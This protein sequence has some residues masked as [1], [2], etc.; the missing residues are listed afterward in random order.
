MT[1]RELQ[2]RMLY[3]VLVAGKS[4][5]F[6]ESKMQ[7][8]FGGTDEPPFVLIRRWDRNGELRNRMVSAKTGNYGKN[9]PAFAELARLSHEG[10][11][12]LSTCSPA[13]LERIRGV[14]PKTSRFFIL[15]TREDARC[16]ALDVHILRWLKQRGYEGI[17]DSTPSGS[18]YERIERMFLD[19]AERLGVTP[20]HLDAVIWDESSRYEGWDPSSLLAER[21][22]DGKDQDPGRAVRDGRQPSSVMG[23]G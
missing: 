2:L 12:D 8:L 16:A 7:T 19:E 9:V 15:W 3:A 5:R 21:I 6:A 4:A 18:R 11:L 13:D 23:Q 17:P 10:V 1:D 22:A 20:R 14:G